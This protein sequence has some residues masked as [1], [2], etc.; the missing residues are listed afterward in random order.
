MPT[1]IKCVVFTYSVAFSQYEGLE[2]LKDS[3]SEKESTEAQNLEVKINSIIIKAGGNSIN[4]KWNVSSQKLFE[5]KY[6][7]ASFDVKL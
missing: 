5:R 3:N 2:S 6:K 1:Q 7:R 4:F